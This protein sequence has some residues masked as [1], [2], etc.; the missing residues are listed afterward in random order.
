MSNSFQKTILGLNEDCLIHIYTFLPIID[1]CAIRETCKRFEMIAGI[2]FSRKYKTMV[3][4]WAFLSSTSAPMVLRNFGVLIE[5]ISITGASS[6][7]LLNQNRVFQWIDR[8]CQNLSILKCQQMHIDACTIRKCP[9]LFSQL[10]KIVIQFSG[11]SPNHY[12]ILETL[13]F[14]CDKVKELQ[15]DNVNIIGNNS[16]MGQTYPNLVS[17]LVKQRCSLNFNCDNWKMFVKKN[18]QLKT[19]RFINSGVLSTKFVQYICDHLPNLEYFTCA[20]RTQSDSNTTHMIKTTIY[21]L[22]KLRKLKKLELCCSG[23][24]CY[25]LLKDLAAKSKSIATIHLV[26][27]NLSDEAIGLLYRIKSLRVLKLTGSFQLDVVKWRA[28]AILLTNLTE[29][30]VEVK[31]VSFKTTFNDTLEF[32]RRSPNLKRVVYY[33]LTAEFLWVEGDFLNLVKCRQTSRNQK[34]PPLEMYLGIY[35]RDRNEWNPWKLERQYFSCYSDI[36]KVA[37][38]DDE[39]DQFAFSMFT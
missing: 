1:L 30:H 6:C 33:A 23:S 8:Y 24:D 22:S 32:V 11:S 14:Y 3:V 21:T 36:I 25:A 12:I 37:Y 20:S 2:Y 29:L 27:P 5:R 9:R 31:P 13:M 16:S 17:F 19:L 35:D 10:E 15:L 39:E 26:D 34:N 38:L 7:S 4:N 18:P 28:L